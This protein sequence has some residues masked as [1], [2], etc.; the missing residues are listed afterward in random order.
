MVN[1]TTEH[2][3]LL[4]AVSV[5][6]LRRV[7]E[8]ASAGAS[9]SGRYDNGLTILHHCA[10]YDESQIALVALDH[11]ANINSKD[12]RERLTP[13]QLAMREESWGVANLLLDRG[14]A[15]GGFNGEQLLS[16]LK[17]HSNELE[18]VK[19][20]VKSLNKRL[21]N[22]AYS[23]DLVSNV[24]DGNDFRTLQLLLEAGFSPNEGEPQTS[25]LE[26]FN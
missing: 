25:K 6:D 1:S 20:L 14:C 17:D 11:G 2:T 7:A 3:A 19:G 12:T 26:Q 8:L 13:F 18:S 16:L 21:R 23:H 5:G 10:L 4:N 15:L 9:F 22:S 24:V